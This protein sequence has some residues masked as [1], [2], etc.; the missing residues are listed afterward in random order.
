MSTSFMHTNNSL[1][2]PCTEELSFSRQYEQHMLC[3]VQLSEVARARLSGRVEF[4][5]G[6]VKITE[7][8]RGAVNTL[9]IS[10]V[11]W[12]AAEAGG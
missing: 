1:L 5:T 10:S 11:M 12:H 7:S 4:C 6:R 8:V 9:Q 2:Y 3:S